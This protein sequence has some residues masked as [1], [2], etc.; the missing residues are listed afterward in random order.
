[1]AVPDNICPTRAAGQ[2]LTEY[3][4]NKNTHPGA[5]LCEYEPGIPMGQGHELR[6]GDWQA[7][8]AYDE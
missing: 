8:G 7:S 5:V 4:G 6:G 3:S 1:M 2:P